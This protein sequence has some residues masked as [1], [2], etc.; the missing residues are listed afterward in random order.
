M[1]RTA[2]APEKFAPLI[3]TAV[4]TGPLVGLNPVKLGGVPAAAGSAD[5]EMTSATIT[6]DAPHAPMIVFRPTFGS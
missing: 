4:P 2:L 6:A 3:V 5:I 1:N